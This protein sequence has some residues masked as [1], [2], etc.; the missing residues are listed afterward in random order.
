MEI[1]EQ[2]Y[3]DRITLELNGINPDCYVKEQ[4]VDKNWQA[5]KE[6][7][8][9]VYLP[10]QP[11][12]KVT[13]VS[14]MLWANENYTDGNFQCDVY[15]NGIKSHYNKNLN[16]EILPPLK[17]NH[18]KIW[19]LV[20]TDAL[21]SHCL[22]KRV[23]FYSAN[24][25][26]EYEIEFAHFQIWRNH[27]LLWACLLVDNWILPMNVQLQHSQQSGNLRL[28]SAWKNRQTLDSFYQNNI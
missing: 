26:E 20:M 15:K 23:K 17:P 5:L 25:A 11:I 21:L 1:T 22:A 19:D 10:S 24:N 3:F 27:D 13:N 6:E 18:Y 16:Y 4:T 8:S 9:I 12:E 7:R 14:I 2:E 28:T